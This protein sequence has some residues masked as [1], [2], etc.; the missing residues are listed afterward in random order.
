MRANS[1]DLPHPEHA[2]EGNL[3]ICFQGCLAPSSVLDVTRQQFDHLS[4]LGKRQFCPQEGSKLLN[5]PMPLQVDLPSDRITVEPND[6]NGVT[7]HPAGH[8]AGV[9]VPGHPNRSGLKIPPPSTA[10][11]EPSKQSSTP[12][13]NIQL[14]I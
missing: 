13:Q 12:R 4:G 3:R 2:G 1:N 6:V 14:N 10:P 7:R 8:P 5:D 11:T 9:R